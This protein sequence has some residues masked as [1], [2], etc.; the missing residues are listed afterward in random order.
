M[1][2]KGYGLSKSNEERVFNFAFTVKD[3]KDKSV[4]MAAMSE[5]YQ[6]EVFRLRLHSNTMLPYL[7]SM[8]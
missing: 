6:Q 2:N 8:S 7:S 4:W 1:I 3:V 5:Q